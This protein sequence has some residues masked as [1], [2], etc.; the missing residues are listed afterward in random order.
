MIFRKTVIDDL[1]TVL[2]IMNL[3]WLKLVDRLQ[4]QQ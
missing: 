3:M 1:K 4:E 2:K